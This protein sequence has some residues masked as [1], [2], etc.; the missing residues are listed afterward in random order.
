MRQHSGAPELKWNRQ[1]TRRIFPP[2]CEKSS[3]SETSG[4]IEGE[5]EWDV[6]SVRGSQRVWGTLFLVYTRELPPRGPG[7]IYVLP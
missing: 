7:S 4:S 2:A 3:G 5:T 1:I 6:S